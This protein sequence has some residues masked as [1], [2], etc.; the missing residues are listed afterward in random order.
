MK[1]NNPRDLCCNSQITTATPLE[2]AAA[3]RHTR[4]IVGKIFS[5]DEFRKKM[6]WKSERPAVGAPAV[7]P[8]V[9]LPA[10]RTIGDPT[11]RANLDVPTTSYLSPSPFLPLGPASSS[12]T[13]SQLRSSPRLASSPL[14]P[15]SRRGRP[16]IPCSQPPPPQ[17]LA[18][19]RPPSSSRVLGG[20][21]RQRIRPR[22]VPS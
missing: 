9:P 2:A 20:P 4:K 14:A 21:R 22:G 1:P 8:A 18:S 7:R 19:P 3:A 17:S 16:S 11:A 15:F 6:N 5:L 13:T 12:S 10:P